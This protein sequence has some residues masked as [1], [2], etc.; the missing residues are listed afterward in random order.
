MRKSRIIF[1]QEKAPTQIIHNAFE[2]NDAEVIAAIAK[3]DSRENETERMKDFTKSDL[4]NFLTPLILWLKFNGLYHRRSAEAK[5]C[6]NGYF[7]F[8]VIYIALLAINA[9]R[10]LT[11]YNVNDDFDQ[12]LFFKFQMSLYSVEMMCHSLIM[13]RAWYSENGLR[14][15]IMQWQVLYDGK[16]LL[17][18]PDKIFLLQSVIVSLLYAICNSLGIISSSFAV[19]D[20]EELFVSTTWPGALQME[21][22]LGPKVLLWGYTALTS[23][24]ALFTSALMCS[25][26]FVIS[27]RFDGLNKEL[28]EVVGNMDQSQTQIEDI[29]A[30]H[31]ALANIVATLDRVFSPFIA[32]VYIIHI[33]MFCVIL[34]NLIYSTLHIS[35]TVLSVF[36]LTFLLLH[37]STISVMAAVVN[38]AVSFDLLYN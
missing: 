30:H 19:P 9:I 32:V 28:S 25:L 35:H 34:Y 13:L 2:K 15:L 16:N 12:I 38:D 7:L 18:R 24:G 11:V 10:T 20:L 29:R 23:N 26:C 17:E 1:V 8:S 6:E 37:L 3:R 14:Y 22:K 21:N 4:Y 31:Q 33:P 5:L 36:W 27:R